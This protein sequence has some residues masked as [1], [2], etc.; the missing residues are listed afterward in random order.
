MNNLIDPGLRRLAEGLEIGPLGYGCWR[1]VNMAAAEAQ[2]RIERAL[3]S[4]MNL[5][6]TADVYGL[7]WGG[8]A[9]GAAEAL[10][11]EVLAG[12]PALR[13]QMVL[14]SKGGII[15]GVPYDSAYLE[16]ACNDSLRRLGVEQLDLYQ[17]HRPDLLCHPE[18]TAQVLEGLRTSGKVREIGVSNYSPSQT[19]ALLAYLP[20]GIASQQPEY[21]A[22]HLAPLFD[23]T[24]DLCMQ[25]G[26]VVLAWSP[27]AGGRL[28]GQADLPAPLLDVLA[29]LAEREGVDQATVA[30]AFV[31]AHPAKPVALVGSIDPDRISAAS[32]ALTVQLDRADVYRIVEATLGE[33]LP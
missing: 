5:I 11:G 7:D 21:S 8:A 19:A 24:F 10:L 29:S 16:Q 30:L 4:G 32:R 22:L 1:L 3:A 25:H 27:L 13:E 17:V 20:D 15:P 26:H 14:A 6:D 28:A 18:E 31:L 33:A 9:F 12:S 2:D 23:G